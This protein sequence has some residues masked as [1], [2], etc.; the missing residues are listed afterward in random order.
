MSSYIR[1]DR[2]CSYANCK[3]NCFSGVFLFGFPGGKSEKYI[4]K[5]KKWIENCGNPELKKYSDKYI[6]NLKICADHFPPSAFVSE[7]KDKLKTNAIPLLNYSSSKNDS[8]SKASENN[9]VSETACFNIKEKTSQ[10]INDEVKVD[11]SIS[12]TNKNQNDG[13]AGLITLPY[14]SYH[15]LQNR[16]KILEKENSILS[17]N[18]KKLLSVIDKSNKNPKRLKTYSKKRDV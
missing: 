15:N 3:N 11:L 7:F 4:E 16:C 9:P 17:K 8:N 1:T 13:K 6:R 18:V 2:R 12:Q 5:K 14:S 10:H